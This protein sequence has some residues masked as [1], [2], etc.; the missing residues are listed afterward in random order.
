MGNSA[1]D[2]VLTSLRLHW[3]GA[4]R[5]GRSFLLVGGASCR[6]M[7]AVVVP[8]LSLVRLFATPGSAACQVSL[9][10]TVS[11]SLLLATASVMPSHHLVLC[12]SRLLLLLSIFPSIRVFSHESAHCIRCP[13][14]WSFCISPSNEYS[15][16]I[17]F[18]IDWFALLTVKGL[19]RIF[20][21]TKAQRHQL[22]TTQ[23]FLLSDSHIHT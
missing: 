18:R 6:G 3:G 10:L 8:L 4:G 17:T 14:Y 21:N 5:G 1:G 15:G 13:E 12:C 11:Q 9:S 2:C 7:K 23:P 20:S 16:L 19:S 22:F